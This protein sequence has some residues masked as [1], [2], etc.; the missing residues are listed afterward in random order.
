M[1]NNI[2]QSGVGNVSIES[3]GAITVAGAI[4][5]ADSSSITLNATTG[6][7]LV[8]KAISTV[9]GLVDIDGDAGVASSVAGTDTG[10]ITTSTAD[11][12]GSSA[13]TAGAVQI[14][15]N[16]GDIT[17]DA[18]IDTSGGSESAAAI[19]ADHGG[20]VTITAADGSIAVASINASGG[21]G[22][23]TTVS[24]GGAGGAVSIAVTDA[25]GTD[26]I[27]VAG[28]ITAV[29][30]DST[31]DAGGAGGAVTIVV[32]DTDAN[33]QGAVSV[34]DIGTAGGDG[35]TTGGSAGAIGITSED[36]SLTLSAGTQLIA[37]A[38]AGGTGVAAGITLTSGGAIT[39][40]SGGT[41][42]SGNTAIEGASLTANAMNGVIDN[43][44][45]GAL[46]SEVGTFDLDATGNINVANV[47]NVTSIDADS[48]GGAISF[49]AASSV[50]VDA[51]WTAP[52]G[53][54]SIEADDITVGAFSLS[55]EN[56]TL[57]ADTMDLGGSTGI[58]ATG[59]TTSNIV[60]LEEL[61]PGTA[62]DLGGGT[63]LGLTDAE[64]DTVTADILRVGSTDAG[65]ISVTSDISPANATNLTLVS[66]ATV[67]DAATI[68]VSG[69]TVRANDVTLD[70]AN[71]VDTLAGQVNSASGDFVYQNDADGFTVG[72][73]DNVAGVTTADSS[74]TGTVTT[75]GITLS[76]TTGAIT[77][78]SVLVTGHATSTPTA[79]NNSATSGSVSITAPA[80][81]NGTGT[82][83][84]GN[85]EANGSSGGIDDATSGGITIL[86]TGGSATL[87][88]TDALQVGTST[89]INADGTDTATGGNITVT[90]DAADIDVLIGAASGGDTNTS[91]TLSVTTD[92]AAAAGN[93]TVNST[94]SLVVS[95][96]DTA[97]GDTQAVNVTLSGADTQLSTS[98]A[99][100]LDQDDVALNA[101]AMT[102]GSTIT[103]SE[104]DLI[105]NDTGQ[106]VNV[107]STA[108]NTTALNLSS[109]ELDGIA[110]NTLR[111]GDSGSGAVSLS[112]AV[113]L[114][115][116]DP[117]LVI[118]SSVSVTD[119][120]AATL[121]VTDLLLT[122]G[123][124]TDVTL[125]SALHSVSTLLATGIRNLTFANGATPLSLGSTVAVDT[126]DEIT[127][128]G[129]GAISTTGGSADITIQDNA[130]VAT[131]TANTTVTIQTNNSDIVEAVNATTTNIQHLNGTVVLEALGTG[132]VG[133]SGSP[134]DI[135]ADMVDLRSDN[136]VVSASPN[137]V[138][139]VMLDGNGTI[140]YTAGT[141]TNITT[142]DIDAGGA[143]MDIS[144]NGNNNLDVEYTSDAGITLASTAIENIG[145]GKVHLVAS[146]GSITG[147]GTVIS[148]TGDVTLEATGA[149]GAAGTPI[150]LSAGRVDLNSSV[151]GD[152]YLHHTG[153][154]V[155]E[156]LGD[157]AN[158]SALSVTG[159]DIVTTAAGSITVNSDVLNPSGGNIILA[160]GT[161]TNT[162]DLTINAT[163]LASGGTGTVSLYSGDDITINSSSVANTGSGNIEVFAGTDYNG[164][165]P[166]IVAGEDGL[167]T[168]DAGASI[169]TVGGS[170]A[171][172]ITS[173]DVSFAAGALIATPVGGANTVTLEERSG[174][175]DFDLGTDTAG[176]VSLTATELNAISTDVVTIGSSDA[177]NID[178]SAAIAPSSA[179]TLALTTAGTITD[180]G[181]IT[182]TNL[183]IRADSAVLDAGHSV[184]TIAAN[185][186][187][188]TGT[189]TFTFAN[190]TALVVGSVDG[191]NGVTNAGTD[192]VT[193]STSSGALSITQPIKTVGALV[194]IDAAAGLT[195]SGA[196]TI[197][198]THDTAGNDSLGSGNV[199]ISVTGAGTIDLGTTITTAGDD[200]SG[201]TGS[202]GGNVTLQTFN[203]TISIDAVD[204][205]G[206][207]GTTTGGNA[208]T[209]SI[210]DTASAGINLGGNLDLAG[211]AGTTS[212]DG[213][214]VTF[215]STVTLDT[216]IS[217]T[218]TGNTD[219]SITFA[220]ITGNH[221]LNLAAGTA[222][223]TL[224][225]V[226]VDT[227]TLTSGGL[228][229]LNGNLEADT[230]LTSVGAINL[231][232][233]VQITAQ[234]S[235][236]LNADQNITFDSANTIT[237]ANTLTLDGG[238]VTV[239]QVGNGTT[240][241]TAF[242]VTATTL[243]LNGSIT[244]DGNVDI[245]SDVDLSAAV[246]IDTSGSNGNITVSGT[247]DGGSALDLIAGIGTVDLN[248]ALGGATALTTLTVTSANQAD[249][250]AV[251]TSGAVD[252]TATTVNIDGQITAGGAVD[253][254]GATT[255]SA[256]ITTSGGSAIT[257][258]TGA[259]TID[260]DVTLDSSTGNGAIN[261]VTDI[262]GAQALILDAGTATVTL[263]G[264]AGNATPLNSLT[265]TGGTVALN[266][267]T[268]RTNDGD[269]S[270]NGNVTSTS[271]LALDS[272][273][274][275]DATDGDI[276]IT[277]T[278]TGGANTINLDADSGSASSVNVGGAITNATTVSITAGSQID[279][280]NVTST[281]AQT[282]TSGVGNAGNIDLNGTTYNSD[283]GTITFNGG[284]DLHAN[285]SINSD[286]NNDVT[287]GQIAFS[288][289]VDGAQSLTVDADTAA[290]NFNGAVGSSTSI[291]TLSV[292]NTGGTVTFAG[293]TTLGTLTTAGNAYNLAFNEDITVTNDV[294]FANTG[295]ITIGNATDDVA[296]F[297]GGLDTTVAGGTK[298][299]NGTIQTS[300]DQADF[301]AITLGSNTTLSSTAGGSTAG[302]VINVGAVT[303]GT[304]DLTF[305]SGTG[306]AITV[307][308]AVAGVGTLDITN[309]DGADL[310]GAV[311]V[312][313]LDI[314]DTEDGSTV[315]VQGDLTATTL[316]TTANGYNV[317]F[318][319]DVT[320]T[321]DVTFANTGTITIGNA[322]DDVATFN[323]GVDTTVAGGTKTLNGTIQTSGDQADFGDITLGS[324][325][326]ILTNNG[327]AAGAILTSVRSR[328]ARTTSR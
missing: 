307:T 115:T 246:A 1:I 260:Q 269:I 271:A 4:S 198:T 26:T 145:S 255:L 237:G 256:G 290:V 172:N 217:V 132:D 211:G 58:T 31:N 68:T 76:A 105:P 243:D 327:A 236:A 7:V 222:A 258:D 187:G 46:T 93:I 6:S 326:T 224:G 174:G 121:T 257:L 245:T 112:G 16:V 190:T 73:P 60:T 272:D 244:V 67:T 109:A 315:Q 238:T 119:T 37:T 110:A 234:D 295:T 166:T 274:D 118:G 98:A 219:G 231:G 54:I 70:N 220:G 38:G 247:I 23:G 94:G 2:T 148:T 116:N 72:S 317:Q 264:A 136:T 52:S 89:I 159:S 268:Y 18:A 229:T 283:D 69:L 165:A 309:S 171:I 3:G 319:E 176:D 13:D 276:L 124:S 137:P 213:S 215:P 117:D 36:A 157:D 162:E 15:S 189:G 20:A 126:I 56:I 140:D 108:T 252:V 49:D 53:D 86:A 311:T 180:A 182:A 321:N 225:A 17:L 308:G 90:A 81:V 306:G 273:A 114:S 25:M 138:S 65:S 151:A 147:T 242:T 297:N 261:I 51:S 296:T 82:V 294:T 64:L 289:T 322:T 253:L 316:T 323:G 77:I 29:G 22:S 200:N 287:D 55:A 259:V 282:Y 175:R 129:T 130:V 113:T 302:G 263:S 80:G 226:D 33:G 8:N 87:T 168:L 221:A 152:I 43:G 284:V 251:T 303:G 71:N 201:A 135:D 267:T 218:T 66:G 233:N 278:L 301:G 107:G 194:D 21:A 131:G 178:V 164:G 122:G 92:G 161:T 48:T 34:N 155:L 47:G 227:L 249:L 125:N 153:N 183:V 305:D 61:T 146:S 102:I 12:D 293:D 142:V 262:N 265:V 304:N 78:S 314:S 75:G 184:G 195:T 42:A 141:G 79:G 280:N 27:T 39:D 111:V 270:L 128:S 32:N 288:D 210:T 134:I 40:S 298:T 230:N 214:S 250:L 96:L 292:Q 35:A 324:N 279:V 160:A 85:A 57:T 44:S 10:T 154:L 310:Q 193:I 50:T 30:G 63:G 208:G 74:S 299:L 41:Q 281:G 313:T 106:A 19:S 228:L 240:D 45:G 177:G 5:T 192:A 149:I 202:L 163:V 223:V 101:D 100:S 232:G 83:T 235:D 104:V 312:T 254:S 291:T 328:V 188:N 167:L 173:D 120:A 139:M 9:G 62:I 133:A 196:G 191:V 205:S 275:N 300:G 241:P 212:G 203:G 84:T 103:A 88:T 206:G 24:D 143:I 209:L 97:D 239:H 156:D 99:I 11:D 179:T 59:G 185:I 285:V 186:S 216:G 150:T 91:G 204:A 14:N 248:G 95:N 207:S 286:A 181:A 169:R 325:T 158:S 170:G 197:T 144:N 266:G 199:D 320:V 318:D 127:I 277:G 123:G 28:L